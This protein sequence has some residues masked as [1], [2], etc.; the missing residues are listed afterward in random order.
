MSSP[1]EGS[2]MSSVSSRSPRDRSQSPTQYRTPM[3][4]EPILTNIVPLASDS[5][6]SPTIIRGFN[7]LDPDVR[8]RQRTLDVDMAMHLSRAR[9]SSVSTSPVA[10]SLTSHL[11]HTPEAAPPTACSRRS[12]PSPRSPS[13]PLRR[14]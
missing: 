2:R 5:R 10:T 8:E 13:P 3:A 4:A 11:H 14:Q 9:R 6:H 7:P 12:T 1:P